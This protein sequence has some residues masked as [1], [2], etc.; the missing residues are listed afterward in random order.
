MSNQEKSATDLTVQGN[1]NAR[2][3]PVPGFALPGTPKEFFDRIM[4]DLSE[5]GFVEYGLDL[6]PRTAVEEVLRIH[7]GLSLTT[8][9]PNDPTP[10]Q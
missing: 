4:A 10:A 6:V 9:L 3:Q 1:F 7:L 5:E 2:L 8:Q